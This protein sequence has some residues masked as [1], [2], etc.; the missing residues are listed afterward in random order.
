MRSKRSPTTCQQENHLKKFG[1]S[2]VF[3]FVLTIKEEKSRLLK[4]GVGPT[5]SYCMYWLDAFCCKKGL[6]SLQA[7]FGN[8]PWIGGTCLMWRGV[9]VSVHHYN[10]K[11]SNLG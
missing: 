3:G 5:L 7:A 8:T 9:A 4:L 11:W 6:K 10:G 1:G 2:L